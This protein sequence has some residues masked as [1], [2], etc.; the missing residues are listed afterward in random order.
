[1]LQWREQEIQRSN[2]RRRSRLSTTDRKKT[3]TLSLGTR[4]LVHLTL[5]TLAM[6]TVVGGKKMTP[7]R[8]PSPN[9]RNLCI[10]PYVA[11]TKG[12]QRCN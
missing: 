3:F 6:L 2:V 4:C 11:K 1:M 9:P 10:L 7:Q 5:G 12:L 8:Y